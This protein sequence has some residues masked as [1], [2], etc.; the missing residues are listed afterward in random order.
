MLNALWASSVPSSTISTAIF[1]KQTGFF[2]FPLSLSFFSYTF[3]STL[4][5]LA[6]IFKELQI[7]SQPRRHLS[8]EEKDDGEGGEGMSRGGVE[9]G[10]DRSFGSER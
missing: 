7:F 10:E 8:S 3:S 5:K 2:F 4:F 9:G 6:T 1:Y